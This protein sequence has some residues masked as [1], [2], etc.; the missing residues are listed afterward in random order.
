MVRQPYLAYLPARLHR[1]L[2]SIPWN[3]FLGSLNVYKFGLSTV[4]SLSLCAM[5]VPASLFLLLLFQTLL[6]LN[7]VNNFELKSKWEKVS[8]TWHTKEKIF[9]LAI[10]RK[11]RQIIF[12]GFFVFVYFSYFIAFIQSHLFNTFIRCHSPR[13]LSIYSSLVS[14]VGKT[15]LCRCWAEN[16][17]R[18]LPY[19]KPTRYQLS[20]AA[21]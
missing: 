1:L 2:E 3:R 4:F 17:T 11:S 8:W 20:H 15:S 21:P 9:R 12:K 7:R 19:S 13:S 14:S 10:R 16:R 6:R 18:G 5:Q